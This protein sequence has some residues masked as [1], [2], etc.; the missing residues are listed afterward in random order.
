LTKDIEAY[1]NREAD[2][3]N[4]LQEKQLAY[5]KISEEFKYYKIEMS[6]IE[7]LMGAKDTTIAR[8]NSDI[9]NLKNEK[10]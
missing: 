8:L 9:S 2:L 5:N 4:E 7:D 1:R 6:G 10:T 3:E